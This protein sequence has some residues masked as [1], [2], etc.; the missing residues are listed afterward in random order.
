MKDRDDNP[1]SEAYVKWH[2]GMGLK[3]AQ[4]ASQ[5]RGTVSLHVPKGFL[6]V[7]EAAAKHCQSGLQT[8]TAHDALTMTLIC[9]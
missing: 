1:I 3:N 6:L 8:Q 9:V 7:V 2:V 4:A 5:P